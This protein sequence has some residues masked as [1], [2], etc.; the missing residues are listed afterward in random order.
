MARCQVSLRVGSY[1]VPARGIL[2]SSVMSSGDVG[3]VPERLER[4][5]ARDHGFCGMVV[6]PFDVVLA[7]RTTNSINPPRTNAAGVLL[8]EVAKEAEMSTPPRQ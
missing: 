4:V 5:A 7:L 2:G 3:R 8:P 1:Q 6:S